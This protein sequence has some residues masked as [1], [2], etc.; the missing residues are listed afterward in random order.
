MDWETG[1][2]EK[3]GWKHHCA[4]LSHHKSKLPGNVPGDTGV[5]S[6]EKGQGWVWKSRIVDNNSLFHSR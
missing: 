6:V 5:L 3:A 1:K 2:D 4:L